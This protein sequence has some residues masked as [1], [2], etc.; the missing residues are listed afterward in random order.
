MLGPYWCSV[1]VSKPSVK[2][3]GQGCFWRQKDQQFEKLWLHYN[4]PVQRQKLWLLLG[5]RWPWCQL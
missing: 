2:L 4:I 1:S 5:L 3:P